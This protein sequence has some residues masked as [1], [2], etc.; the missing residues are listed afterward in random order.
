MLPEDRPTFFSLNHLQAMALTA[1]LE[2]RGQGTIGMIAVLWTIK[3]RVSKPRWW[4]TNP[5]QVCY[6]DKQFSCFNGSNSEYHLAVSTAA[7]FES[8]RVHDKALDLAYNLASHVMDG[9][10]PDP[11]HGA[12]NYI[13]PRHCDPSWAKDNHMALTAVI[14]DHQ[15][16]VEV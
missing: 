5:T 9:E 1:W 6:H 12:T 10:Y 11:T 15:F 13:N 8:A 7:S 16:Y 2:A 4:G 14:G 3:N